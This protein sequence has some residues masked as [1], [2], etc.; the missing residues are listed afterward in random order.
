[1]KRQLGGVPGPGRKLSVCSMLKEVM[2]RLTGAGRKAPAAE[3][4]HHHCKG[5]AVFVNQQV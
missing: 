1:M 5:L 4:D 3:E 2:E